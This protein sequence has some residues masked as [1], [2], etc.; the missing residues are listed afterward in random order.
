[1]KLL[2]NIK[3]LIAII[4]AIIMSILYTSILFWFAYWL[5]EM[6][7]L[8]FG[9]IELYMDLLDFSLCTTKIC[10]VLQIGVLLFILFFHALTSSILYFII[11]DIID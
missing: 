5:L 6:P 8:N 10:Y 2:T 7:F 1:M 3:E 4:L 9:C 11:H